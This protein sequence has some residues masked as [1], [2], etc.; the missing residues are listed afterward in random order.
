MEKI[1]HPTSNIERPREQDFARSLDVRRWMLDVGCSWRFMG[2]LG[3]G[4]PTSAYPEV[5]FGNQSSHFQNRRRRREETLNS[6]QFEP[7]Y[8]VSYDVLKERQP[9]PRLLFCI[10]EP[11]CIGS[12]GF[13]LRESESYLVRLAYDIPAGNG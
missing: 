2:R 11:G 9:S 13:A 8:L 5:Y 10:E 1:Q 7:R 3:V 4:L 12:R 6:F